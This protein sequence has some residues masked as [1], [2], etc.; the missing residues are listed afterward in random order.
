MK[1]DHI[2]MGGIFL[3]GLVYYFLKSLSES[4]MLF[5]SAS[6]IYLLFLRGCAEYFGKK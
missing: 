6:V 2:Y 1:K 4:D 5:V 3:F